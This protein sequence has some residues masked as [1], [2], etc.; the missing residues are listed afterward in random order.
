[1]RTPLLLLAGLDPTSGAGL[2]A[3]AL[4][5]RDL[6]CHP[7]VVPSMLTVQNSRRFVTA[8][9]V[10]P[11]YIEHA[12]ATLADEF[13]FDTV[14]VGIVPAADAAWLDAVGRILHGRCHRFVIDPVLRPTATTQETKPG[15][16]YLAFLG[17]AV[18]TPNQRELTLLSEAAGIG[19]HDVATAARALAKH[20]SATIV[21]T[22]EGKES[23]VLVAENGI[24]TDIPLTLLPAERPIHGTGC[25]FSTAV[26]CGLARGKDIVN[27][28]ADAVGYLTTALSRRER[29]HPDGQD[30]L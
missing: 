26:A 17:G 3:D 19:E 6:G 18:I 24:T 27:A 1:M 13:S 21:V 5:A 2:V 30:F 23:R 25:R 12:V 28:V 29:F 10:S 20:L 7:L 9:A 22:F 14:K 11:T 15:D 8:E 16:A 4:T